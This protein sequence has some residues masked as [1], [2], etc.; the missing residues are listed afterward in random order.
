MAIAGSR[1][2]GNT[3][4]L[5]SPQT[6]KSSGMDEGKLHC[7]EKNSK[8]TVNHT[9]GTSSKTKNGSK[10]SVSSASR[11]S[12]FLCVSS[13]DDEEPSAAKKKRRI[14]VVEDSDDEMDS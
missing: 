1:K 6:D 4:Y 10:G 2:L 9:M 13:S 11:S 7:K 8:A 5:P 14:V 12:D 3:S